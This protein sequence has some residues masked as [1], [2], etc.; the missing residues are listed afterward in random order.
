[1]LRTPSPVIALLFVTIAAAGCAPGAAPARVGK[2]DPPPSKVERVSSTPVRAERVVVAFGDVKR[3]AV[4]LE[5]ALV[6]NADRGDVR[7]VLVDER[8]GELVIVGTEAGIARARAFLSPGL[9]EQGGD[10]IEV[11]RLT[12]ADAQNV[13][14]V[15][16]SLVQGR[17]R[18]VPDTTMNALVLSGDVATRERVKKVVASLD[19]EV[20]KASRAP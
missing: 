6:E 15:V 5:R 19:V 12:H 2:S 9:I 4:M 11:L 16:T 13:A 1:M 7:A 3:V 8:S 14:R 20:A 17:V 10:E 18:V